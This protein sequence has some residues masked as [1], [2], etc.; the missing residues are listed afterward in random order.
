MPVVFVHGMRVSGT[1]W[2]PVME[3]VEARHPVE[4]PDLPGHGRRRGESFTLPAAVDAV[5]EAI[6]RLGGRALVVGLSLGGY[7]AIATA[8]RHPDKVAGLVA[9]GCTALPRGLFAAAFRGVARAAALHPPTGNRVSA[10][11]FRRQLPRPAAQALIGG[12]L[13]SEVVPAVV[14]AVIG[15]D[16]PAALAAYPGPVWLAYG[17]KDPFRHDAHAFVRACRDGRLVVWPGQGHLTCLADPRT[18]ARL[19]SDAAAVV[20]RP[21]YVSCVL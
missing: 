8:K 6:D 20:G 3:A 17:T 15:F 7:V 2:G 18:V 21:S 13:T 9:I 11:G 5:A 16:P 19:V 1:M 4:A 14:G 10:W 12:G